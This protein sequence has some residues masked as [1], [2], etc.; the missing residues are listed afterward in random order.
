MGLVHEDNHNM[1]AQGETV[2]QLMHGYNT[3]EDYDPWA[4]AKGHSPEKAEAPAVRSSSPDSV[5]Q[6][7]K[8]GG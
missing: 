5:E 7:S 3:P 1:V 6:R 8:L 4:G 2:A